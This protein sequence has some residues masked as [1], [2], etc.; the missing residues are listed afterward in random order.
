MTDADVAKIVTRI[1]ARV[2]RKLRRM[3]KLPDADEAE[4]L[5][6]LPG[7]EEQLLMDLSSAAV[8]GRAALGERPGAA[9]VRVGRGRRADPFV[10]AALCADSDGFSLHAA[11]RVRAGDRK[12]LEHLCRYAGRSAIA[13]SRLSELPDGRLCYALKRTWKDGTTHIVLTPQVLIE[14][15]LALVPRPRR[16]QLTYYGVLAPAAGLRSRVVPQ[17]ELGDEVGAVAGAPSVPAGVEAD[18]GDRSPKRDLVP[19][20]PAARRR[21]VKRRYTW[22]SLLRRVFLVDVLQCPHCGGARRLLAAVYDPLSI[23]AVLRAMGLAPEAP[24]LAPARAPPGC[25]QAWFGA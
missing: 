9:D 13:E 18:H 15:L 21:G 16:H 20:R 8:Q 11:V 1:R 24:E 19:H 3:G 22:A 25:G 5:A 10:K 14:R 12:R 2:V 23:E 17:R 4:E 6:D 7:G